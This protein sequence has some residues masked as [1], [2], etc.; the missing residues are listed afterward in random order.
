MNDDFL[1]PLDVNVTVGTGTDNL[2]SKYSVPSWNRVFGVQTPL[3]DPKHINRSISRTP[4]LQSYNWRILM[5]TV[6]SL[7]GWVFL[8]IM[9]NHYMWFFT[10]V[11]NFRCLAWLEVYQETTVLKVLLGGHWW[12]LTE[13]LK[14]G[15]TLYILYNHDMQFFSCVSN[16]SS[17]AWLE[18]NQEPLI[19]ES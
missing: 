3:S 17:L 18:V 12:L 13:V 14:D 11:P 4:C 6:W 8:D 15:V 2:N 19:L 5:V 1:K 7:G 9:N 16:I 10:C